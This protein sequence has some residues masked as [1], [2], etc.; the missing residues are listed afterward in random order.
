MKL[1]RMSQLSQAESSILRAEIF[2]LRCSSI[3][4]TYMKARWMMFLLDSDE[5]QHDDGRTPAF[6]LVVQSLTFH[7]FFSSAF[8]VDSDM[9]A[10]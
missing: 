8:C 6:P 5:S 3:R 10:F 7:L 4:R 2:H 9:Q 1:F